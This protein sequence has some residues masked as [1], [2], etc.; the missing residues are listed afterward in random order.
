MID[1]RIRLTILPL[2]LPL[3]EE[4]PGEN[5][6]HEP[7]RHHQDQEKGRAEDG[8]QRVPEP[9]GRHENHEKEEYEY[10]HGTLS[11]ST[12]VEG[13]GGRSRRRNGEPI[14]TTD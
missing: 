6:G 8:G 9:E 1:R 12:K 13:P 2:G 5:Q 14:H 11:V 3:E 10:G 7:Q 4:V